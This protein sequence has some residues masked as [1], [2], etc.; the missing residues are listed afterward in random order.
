V[1][2]GQRVMSSPISLMTFKAVNASIPSICVRSPPVVA[3][4]YL[5]TSKPGVCR[6]RTPFA[7]RRRL[8]RF[9]FHMCHKRLETRVNLLL[10]RLQLL[11]QKLILLQGLLQRK[12]ILGPP[13]PFQCLG[14]RSLIVCAPPITVAS[15]TLGIA[16]ACEDGAQGRIS[17]VHFI[18]LHVMLIP[19]SEG[20]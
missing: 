11:L 7:G 5:W 1:P 20:E 18:I 10:A 6:W 14:D 17:D 3:S 15:Q 8:R 12:E 16:L 13:V 9:D 2:V 19:S 4:R